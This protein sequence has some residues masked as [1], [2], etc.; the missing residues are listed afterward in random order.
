VV[1]R[2]A[3]KAQQRRDKAK[4]AALKPRSHWLRQAQVAFNGWIRARDADLGC[5]SCGTRDGKV[6]AGHY[7]SVAACPELRFEPLNVHRQCER[8]N[9][10][11]HGNLIHYRE[12]LKTLIWKDALEW[13]E[14]PHEPKHYT[15]DELRA[16][17]A[18][19]RAET[20]RQEPK[21]E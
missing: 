9:T 19:W 7:R 6:N 2:K 14:G 10:F 16:M 8:C 21:A 15:T 5:I 3:D 18:H 11:L 13:L 4:L 17:A 12:A 20:R 1:A